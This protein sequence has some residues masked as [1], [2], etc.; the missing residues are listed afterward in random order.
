MADNLPEAIFAGIWLE[1]LLP[2]IIPE[3][4]V[5]KTEEHRK[6]LP[7]QTSNAN[8]MRPAVA[9][10]GRMLDHTY[11]P[12]EETKRSGLAQKEISDGSETGEP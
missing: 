9:L 1:T 5:K 8:M 6:Q 3:Q 7:R 11:A 4:I 12:I 2:F 10:T